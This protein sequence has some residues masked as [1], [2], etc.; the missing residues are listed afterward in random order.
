VNLLRCLKASLED[1]WYPTIPFQGTHF[2]L[3]S[4]PPSRVIEREQ[5]CGQD[6][7]N[8]RERMRKSVPSFTG[9]RLIIF[10]KV[11]SNLVG[12]CVIFE[13]QGSQNTFLL[14]TTVP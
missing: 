11:N 9:G 4:I 2:M 10:Q 12:G 13:N 3:A 7:L 5:I 8:S 6:P 14:R 1:D